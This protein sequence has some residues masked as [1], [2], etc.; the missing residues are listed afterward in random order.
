MTHCIDLRQF[1][2]EFKITTE[3]GSRV[4]RDIRRS[5]PW[6]LTLPCRLG[7][8]YPHGGEFLGASTDRRGPTANRLASLPGVR[9]VQDG[10]D[11]VNVVFE[12]DRFNQVAEIMG[13]RSRRRLSAEQKAERAE[14]LRTHRFSSASQ[15]AGSERRR[16]RAARADSEHQAKAS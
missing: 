7:H 16:V 14:R 9:V 13:P 2:H 4:Y 1:R 3:D 6:L 15:D 11:G 8:I 10:D 5:D 12:L